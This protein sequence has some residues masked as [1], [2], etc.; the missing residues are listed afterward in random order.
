MQRVFVNG[1]EA[2]AL[3]LSQLLQNLHENGIT[4]A[5]PKRNSDCNEIDERE[6]I[7]V[8]AQ[9][10]SDEILSSGAPSAVASWQV[11]RYLTTAVVAFSTTADNSSSVIEFWRDNASSG[12]CGV[13]LS[14]NGPSKFKAEDLTAMT[15]RIE[16][17]DSPIDISLRIHLTVVD[18]LFALLDIFIF[19]ATSSSQLHGLTLVR[20]AE[21]RGGNIQGPVLVSLL[22]ASLFQ[23]QHLDLHRIQ[24]G[25]SYSPSYRHRWHHEVL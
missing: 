12:L 4:L 8:T 10:I 21:T 18:Q 5:T 24:V 25:P 6:P 11:L 23:L 15:G 7:D 9:K 16:P 22:R 17:S 20:G 3:I 1:G 14:E 2:L 13:L 19:P